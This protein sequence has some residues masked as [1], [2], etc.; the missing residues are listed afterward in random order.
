MIEKEDVEV[1]LQA[2]RRQ[3]IYCWRESWMGFRFDFAENRV[4][5]PLSV[6]TL[7]SVDQPIKFH[8]TERVFSVH[9]LK[10]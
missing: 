4:I 8:F 9:R 2:F 1:K 6:S 10:Y 3:P 5:R 7:P